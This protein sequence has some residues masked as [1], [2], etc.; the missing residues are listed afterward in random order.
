MYAAAEEKILKLTHMVGIGEWVAVWKGRMHE[1]YSGRRGSN[2]GYR[3][4]ILRYPESSTSGQRQ[5]SQTA[6]RK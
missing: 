5:S 6:Y 1:I 3:G 2:I 4:Q